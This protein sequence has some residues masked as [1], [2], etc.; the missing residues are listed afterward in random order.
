MGRVEHDQSPRNLGTLVGRGIV[1]ARVAQLV[2]E[3]R[4]AL[5]DEARSLAQQPVIE[6]NADPLEFLQQLALTIGSGL[7]AMRA[8]DELGGGDSQGIDPAVGGLQR[9]G[10]AIGGDQLVGKRTERNDQLA[11][12]L[13]EARTRLEFG[14]SV[15]QHPRK[16][17]TCN[18][19]ARSDAEATKN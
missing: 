5:L 4:A 6:S 14:H 10:L 15:P 8:L 18:A 16:A 7:A 17:A 13:T 9:D 1:A 19:L 11:E 3:Q 2:L 12:R